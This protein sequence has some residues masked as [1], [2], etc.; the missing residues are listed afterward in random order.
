[1]RIVMHGHLAQRSPF[2][3]HVAS[4]ADF[5]NGLPVHTPLPVRAGD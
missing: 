5:A 1:M 2:E 4:N 3:S